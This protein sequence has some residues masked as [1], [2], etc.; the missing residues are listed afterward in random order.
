MKSHLGT[1]RDLTALTRIVFSGSIAWYDEED[2]L[3]VENFHHDVQVIYCCRRASEDPHD[4]TCLRLRFCLD[5]GV[6]WIGDLHVVASFRLR[7]LGRQLV[8]ASEI[9]ARK[10][11]MHSAHVFPFLSSRSFWG[12]MGYRPHPCTARV[13]T[14]DLLDVA[15]QTPESYATPRATNVCRSTSGVSISPP[16]P[17]GPV[18]TEDPRPVDPPRLKVGRTRRF[19]G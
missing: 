15:G 17:V 3:G 1:E 7:G 4:R 13:L 8:R 9:T 14:L 19:L 12:K 11:G 2:P 18:R 10:L 5:T 16:C 6:L